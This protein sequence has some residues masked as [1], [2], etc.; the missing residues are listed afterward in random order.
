MIA[1][2]LIEGVILGILV[3]LFVCILYLNTFKVKKSDNN[4]TERIQN[5]SR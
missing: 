2:Y 3:P 4:N 1:M 5:V